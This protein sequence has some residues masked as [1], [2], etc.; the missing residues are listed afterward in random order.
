MRRCGSGSPAGT[1]SSRPVWSSPAARCKGSSSWPSGLV[2]PGARVLVEAPTYDRPLKILTRLGAEIVPRGDGRRR[3]RARGARGG[4]CRRREARAPVHDR[5]LPEPE[6]AHAL[7]RPPP[8]RRRDRASARAPG[9]G[10]RSPTGS[11][12]SRA[13]RR[14]RSSHWRAARTSPTASSFSK[15]VAPGVRVGYFV[16]PEALAVEIEQL[17][18]STYI[19]PPFLTQATVF[20]FVRRGNFEPNLE[21]VNGLLQTSS[22]CDARGAR[23][24]PRRRSLVEPP[25]GWVLHL[26]RRSRPALPRRSYS[27]R[28]G[29]GR[30][31]RERH[32]FLPPGRWGRA[33][34]PACLQLRLARGDRRRNRRARRTATRCAGACACALAAPGGSRRRGRARG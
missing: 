20:E 33:F 22:R 16:L 30:D 11:S 1:A 7:A 18:V 2:R 23:A 5:H 34:S 14:R 6:R 8:A 25:R 21:R 27:A 4:S 10:G 29:G 26:A 28:R 19:S 17:A 24:A 13:M 32:G 31:V 12:A 3:P 15:T 9:A